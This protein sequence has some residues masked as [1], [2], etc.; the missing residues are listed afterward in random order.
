MRSRSLLAVLAATLSIALAAPAHADVVVLNDGTVYPKGV[1]LEAGQ[2]PNPQQLKESRNLKAKLGHDK[3]QVGRSSV[4]SA[5]VADVYSYDAERNSIY[6]DAVRLAAS[7]AFV[8]AAAMFADAATELEGTGKEVALYQAMLAQQVAWQNMDDIGAAADA[9]LAAFPKGFYAGPALLLKA[10]LAANKGDATTARKHLDAITGMTGMNARDYF[11]AELAKVQWFKLGTAGRD[12]GKLADAERSFR[13]IA[14]AAGAKGDEARIQ[15][16]KALVGA[17]R[18]LVYLGKLPEAQREFEAITKDNS[19]GD[20][21]LL[22]AAY[23]GLGDAIYGQAREAAKDVGED[24]AKRGAVLKSLTEAALHYFRVTEFYGVDYAPDEIMNATMNAA[25]V[26]AS[27]FVISG[28]K[29]CVLGR[30]A[31]RYYRTAYGLM[32]RGEAKTQFGREA[33]QF[34][35]DYDAGCKVPEAGS[36]N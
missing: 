9:Y 22:A 16:L 10:R 3:V 24:E 33:L 20:K 26:L 4:S 29:D 25:R 30:R 21:T 11:E 8:D 34:K 14:S 15:K 36:G 28:G 35:K 27:Q 1:E 5:L 32:G 6:A 2:A 12:K 17:G 19:V 23:N 7:G 31:Y 18:C 13:Q